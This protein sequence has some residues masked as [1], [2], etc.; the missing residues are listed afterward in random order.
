[1]SENRERATKE[2][3]VRTVLSGTPDGITMHQSE[4][5]QVWIEW[6]QRGKPPQNAP[7][8]VYGPWTIS[9]QPDP[10]DCGDGG[11]SAAIR[12]VE[13]CESDAQSYYKAG[14]WTPE[15]II[16]DQYLR[17]HDLKRRVWILRQQRDA[18]IT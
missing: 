5:L 18:Y 12:K 8:T 13:D 10:N 7:L 4:H 16:K 1:M 14:C 17:L 11:G 2:M 9:K 6:P 3:L 15:E